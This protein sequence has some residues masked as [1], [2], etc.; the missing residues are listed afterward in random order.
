M[1]KVETFDKAQVLKQA[2]LVFHEKGYNAAS[3]QDLVD[4]TGLNRSSIYNSFGGKLNLFMA[5]LKSYKEDNFNKINERISNADNGLKAIELLLELY[6]EDIL[7]DNRDMGCL[8][9]N[10][11][12]EMGNQEPLISKFLD[13]NM[14][15]FIDFLTDLIGKA[16]EE[17]IINNKRTASE[18]ALYMYSSIQGFRTTGI[19]FSKKKDLKIL[20]ETILQTLK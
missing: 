18:Y 6:L 20:I 17:G 2:T 14:T 13:A 7:Q 15:S 12:T 5:C 1:P 8:L 9:T 11:A 19:L 3:M 10:C 4:A 16:Q